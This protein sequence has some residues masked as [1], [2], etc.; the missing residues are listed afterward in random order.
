MRITNS[1]LTDMVI[2]NTQKSLARYLETSN[3]IAS[4]RRINKPSDDPLGIVKDLDLKASLSKNAQYQKNINEAQNWTTTY[5]STIGELSNLIT[6]IKETAISMA[7]G[8]YDEI[9]REAAA[10]EVESLYEQILQLSVTDL[11]G[12]YLFSGYR[13]DGEPLQTTS[14]GVRYDGDDGQIQFQIGSSSNINVNLLG[15]DIF[16]AQLSVLGEDADLELGLSGSTLLA[17]LNAGEGIDQT[18]GLITITDENLGVAVDVD[19]SGA[20]TI[21][22][23]INEITNALSANV[24]P[25][26]NLTVEIGPSGNSLS[27][28]PTDDG[29]ISNST[30]LSVLNGGGGI[31][32]SDGSV[33]VTDNAGNDL[34][35]DMTGAETVGDIITKFNNAITADPAINDLSMQINASGT[36]FEIVDN[37]PP[38]G[39]SIAE[40]SENSQTAASLGIVGDIGPSLVGEDLNPKASFKIDENGG[41]TAADLGILGSFQEDFFGDDLD[42]RLTAMSNIADFNNANGFEWGNIILNQGGETRRIDLSDSSIVTVQDMLDTINNCGLNITASINDSGMGFQI[43][44]NDPYQ[45]F[46]IQDETGSRLTKDLGIYGSSDMMGSVLILEDALRNNDQEAAGLLIEN[47]E[48]ATQNLLNHRASVGAR[49]KRLEETTTML[50]GQELTLTE[51]LSEV[52]DA[53]LTKLVTDLSTYEANYQAALYA[54]AAIIQPTLL[55]FLD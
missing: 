35:I 7:N 23:V 31:D 43:V 38:Q 22:D 10:N 47:M 12:K 8:T 1:M 17:D 4:G 14:N 45:S 25:I 52:E 24:P 50:T 5:D 46:T 48:D 44:N 26:T 33:L 30:Q 11:Q 51:R 53:D 41:T 49:G 3:Q 15:S 6:S 28:V 40:A 16:M 37:N 27:F 21:D 54:S 42:P 18:T 19:L 39:F 13:T 32:F 55:N 36:G 20:T 9:A 2:Y 29:Q 34:V